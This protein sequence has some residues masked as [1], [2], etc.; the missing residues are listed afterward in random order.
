MSA[1]LIVSTMAGG[2]VSMMTGP[3]GLV[4]SRVG[5]AGE[6]QPTIKAQRIKAVM[7]FI[8]ASIPP[9]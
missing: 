2:I 5:A 4:G 8:Q 3:G 1:G 9:R 6:A 7:S